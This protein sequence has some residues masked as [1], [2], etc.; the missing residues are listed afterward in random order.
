MLLFLEKNINYHHYD[1]KLK[2]VN[3]FLL[4]VV[5]IIIN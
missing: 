4:Y 5:G 2:V 1:M 3:I